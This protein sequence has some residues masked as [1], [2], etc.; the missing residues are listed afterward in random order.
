MMINTKVNYCY[1]NSTIER[2]RFGKRKSCINSNNDYKSIAKLKKQITTTIR[3]M[4]NI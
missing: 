4:A 1:D 2:C 3:T